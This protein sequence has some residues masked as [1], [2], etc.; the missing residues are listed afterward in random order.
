MPTWNANTLPVTVVPFT[1]SVGPTFQVEH[2]P[3]DVFQHFLPDQFLQNIC[4][5]TNLYAEQVMGPARY[6]EWKEVNV[7]EMKAYI[8]FSVLMGLVRLPA[9]ED[10]WKVDPHL[11]YA[12][13]ADRISRQRFRDISDNFFTSPTLFN[14][15]LQDGIYA[16][17]TARMNRKGF[18]QDLKV[19]RIVK[20]R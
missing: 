14:C 19:K 12:P 17:G 10:Y 9:I 1:S 11:H 3:I 4:V 2:S 6:L 7:I 5:Q 18:P 16:C 8:G 13:I 20:N 15:L